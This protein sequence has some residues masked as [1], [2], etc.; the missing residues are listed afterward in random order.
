MLPFQSKPQVIQFVQPLQS[1]LRV[2]SQLSDE[3]ALLG[4]FFCQ[5]LGRQLEHQLI[6]ADVPMFSDVF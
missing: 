3:K 4:V 2:A 1:P 5:H 6:E